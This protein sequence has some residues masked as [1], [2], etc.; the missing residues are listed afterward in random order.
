MEPVFYGRQK[1]IRELEIVHSGC[2]WLTRNTILSNN[3]TFNGP[4]MA[5]SK[6]SL[7][8][9]LIFLLSKWQPVG[10]LSNTILMDF[11]Q[12][13]NDFHPS[14]V[15]G[16]LFMIRYFGRKILI[17]WVGP[18]SGNIPRW[19]AVT[20]FLKIITMKIEMMDLHRRT[21]VVLNLILFKR[22]KYK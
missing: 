1:K 20:F 6:F 21:M 4:H 3:I 18:E 7:D 2:W 14:T 12:I 9:Y 22:Q 8:L 11:F 17:D 13:G 5:L 15:A 16:Q 19:S 10:L